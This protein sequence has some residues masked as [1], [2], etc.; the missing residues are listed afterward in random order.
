MVYNMKNLTVMPTLLKSMFFQGNWNVSNMQGTGFKW[1]VKDFFKR[2]NTPL[3]EDFNTSSGYYFNTNPYLVTFILGLL[4]KEMRQHGKIDN[5]DKIYSSAFAAM[6]DTFFWHSL[7]P[8]AFFISIWAFMVS[9][10]LAVLL[11]FIVFNTFNIA[12]RI[13][14]FYYGYTF[15]RDVILIFNKIHFNMWSRIY[16]GI[17]VFMAGTVIT[18]IIK[19]QYLAGSVH[20]IKSVLLFTVS[21][22]ISKWVRGPAELIIV[23]SVLGTLLLFGV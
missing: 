15:G 8:F 4:L 1:L 6:G 13:L 18:Y 14:G 3:P 19:Y 10:Y 7:R 17:T 20:I 11:Y 16:D 12:F 21:I 23:T 9:P 5:Y 2:N 22:F